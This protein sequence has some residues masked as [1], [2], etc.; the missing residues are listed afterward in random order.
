VFSTL[1]AVIFAVGLVLPGF[2]TADLAEAGRASRVRR[3]DW[4][5]VLRALVYALV[6]H[7]AVFLAGWTP[8][9]LEDLGIG[10]PTAETS[11]GTGMQ[12]RSRSM[13]WL[14]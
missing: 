11:L 1:V 14:S 5:L 12:T 4:E 10:S 8:Q 3:S 2:I 7:T 13:C 6:L 9:L